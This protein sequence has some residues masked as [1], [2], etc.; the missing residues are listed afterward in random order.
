MTNDEEQLERLLDSAAVRQRYGI[1]RHTLQDWR[2]S[3][4]FPEPSVVVNKRV[5]YWDEAAVKQWERART[6]ANRAA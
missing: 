5:H 1:T 6:A 3:F 4:G 2:K